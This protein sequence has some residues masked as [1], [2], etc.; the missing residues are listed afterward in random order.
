MWTNSTPRRGVDHWVTSAGRSCLKGYDPVARA[1]LIVNP[2]TGFPAARCLS[3]SGM[4]VLYCMYTTRHCTVC[5]SVCLSEV[6]GHC[7]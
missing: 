1:S 5:M 2:Y 3:V 7:D 6:I 4:Y